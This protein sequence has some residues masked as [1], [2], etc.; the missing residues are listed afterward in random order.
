VIF[1]AEPF[2]HHAYMPYLID[3]D[4]LIDISRGKQAAR[5]YLDA[6]IE[7]WA[8]SQISALELIVGA[9]DKRDLANIDTFLSAYVIVPLRDSTGR[10]AYELLKLYA[11]PHGLHVFDSLVAATTIEEGLTLVTKN[12]RHF[13]AIDSLSLEIPGY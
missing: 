7:G 12:R 4:V 3:S 2:L 10:R 1:E 13:E 6:L 11:K 5:E 8:I 9:R